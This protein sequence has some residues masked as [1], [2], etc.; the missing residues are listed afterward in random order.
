MN[1]PVNTPPTHIG[2]TKRN[3]GASKV[4]SD[5]SCLKKKISEIN[6]ARSPLTT[7]FINE[8]IQPE[9]FLSINTFILYINMFINYPVTVHTIS[10]KKIHKRRA[11]C[12]INE[13]K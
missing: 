9:K 7:L 12:A 1:N 10:N 8:M 4:L 3:S 6:V 5:E 11:T 13:D 2:I